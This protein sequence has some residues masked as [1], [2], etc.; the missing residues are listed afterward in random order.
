MPTGHHP[1]PD[2][3]GA[4]I[5]RNGLGKG[6]AAAALGVTRVTLWAWLNRESA[7]SDRCRKDIATWTKG[8]VAET[9]WPPLIDR[10][11]RHAVVKP[12]AAAKP[13]GTAA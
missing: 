6:Q 13:K 10:R 7:P 4:F 1:G 12:F 11:K 9:A 8:E 5:E 3:L 2:L